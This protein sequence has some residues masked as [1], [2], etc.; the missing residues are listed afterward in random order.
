MTENAEFEK[1]NTA[2]NTILKTDPNAVKAAMEGDKRDRA[3]RRKAKKSSA[4][5]AS[6]GKGQKVVSPTLPVT[7][8]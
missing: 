1:F 2:M 5:R 3:K 4:V 7:S 8:A 6:S